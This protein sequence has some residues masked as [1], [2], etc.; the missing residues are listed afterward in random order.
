MLALWK[1]FVDQGTSIHYSRSQNIAVQ[2]ANAVLVWASLTNVIYLVSDI[3]AR[4]PILLFVNGVASVCYLGGLYLIRR[5]RPTLATVLGAVGANFSI[6]LTTDAVGG[7]SL[8]SLYSIAAVVAPFLMIDGRRTKSIL[9]VSLMG[10]MSFLFSMVSEDQTLLPRVEPTWAHSKWFPMIITPLLSF[11]MVYHTYRLFMNLLTEAELRKTEM[12]HQSRMAALGE[13]ASGIAHEINNPLQIIGS[14]A[15]TIQEKLKNENVDR[16]ALQKAADRIENTTYRIARIVTGLL[17]FARGERVQ[18]REP[19]SIKA[20]VEGTLDLCRERSKVK[21]VRL[22]ADQVQDVELF[23]RPT[24]ISQIILNLVSN[25]LDAASEVDDKWIEIR[26][27]YDGKKYQI[28]VTDSGR[29]IP[30]DV[31][32]KMM[33]PFFTTKPVGRGTGLGLSISKGII[34][35]HGG[36]IYYDPSHPDTKFVVEIPGP[37]PSVDAQADTEL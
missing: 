32:E 16:E 15:F 5:G 1:D 13:M 24:Q 10:F 34:E 11:A 8:I 37:S 31:A 35:E 14:S 20:I 12:F 28:E 4:D 6:V 27:W 30:T 17:N 25:S 3:V 36:R 33:Q 29:R 18:E 7:D 9:F 19:Y 21:G 23:V 26:G 22:G 2:N